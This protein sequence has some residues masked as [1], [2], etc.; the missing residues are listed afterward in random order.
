MSLLD[1]QKAIGVVSDLLSTRIS[2]RLSN[3]QVSVGRPEEAA[4]RRTQA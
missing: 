3:M 4:D 2:M 1:S